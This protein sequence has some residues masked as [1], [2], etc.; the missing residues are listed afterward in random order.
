MQYLIP[1]L[2][3]GVKLLINYDLLIP[4]THLTLI[5]CVFSIPCSLVYRSAN[6]RN[7]FEYLDFEN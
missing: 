4:K 1:L 6:N 5:F 3:V 2:F 7:L